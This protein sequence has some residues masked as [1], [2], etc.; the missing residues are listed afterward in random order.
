LANRFDEFVDREKTKKSAVAAGVGSIDDEQTVVAAYARWAP[1]YDPIFGV[2]TGIGRK[3]AVSTLNDLPDGRILEV[4][5]GTG[6]SLPLYKGGH[7]LVGID[8]SP[9]MLVRAKKR[10]A[11]RALANVEALHE[12]DAAQLTF[13]EASFDVAVAMFVMTVVPDPDAVLAEI[14]RVVRPGG[15]VVVVNHFSVEKGPRAALERSLTRYSGALGWR[16][17]FPIQEVLGRS[18]L[19]LLERRDLPPAGIFTLLVFERL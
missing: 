5:V 1:V 18:D 14:V 10:V 4:G 6:I 12:M 13:A 19:N 17:E 3:A 16:P 7:R 9:D 8:L 11:R 15:H 2:A